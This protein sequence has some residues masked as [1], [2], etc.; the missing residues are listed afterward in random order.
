MIWK[1]FALSL[2]KAQQI[3]TKVGQLDL[4]ETSGPSSHCKL[5]ILGGIRKYFWPWPNS[6]R[7]AAAFALG[8]ASLIAVNQWNSINQSIN[9]S[10]NQLLDLSRRIV[11]PSC[12]KT[13]PWWIN[14]RKGDVAG[15]KLC[16]IVKRGISCSEKGI[17][18]A[19]ASLSSSLG[20]YLKDL[21]VCFSPC[22]TC[23]SL[24]WCVLQCM[25]P[26]QWNFWNRN[27]LRCLWV[28]GHRKEELWKQRMKL[29][30]QIARGSAC[31]CSV[32][33]NIS[34]FVYPL[35]WCYKIKG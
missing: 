30:F 25:I 20:H 10:I 29:K 27:V 22:W 32:F 35:G 18:K 12:C 3:S 7:A 17:L 6:G 5:G 33:N 13:R 24:T 2:I 16:F 9:L 8:I 15:W 4:E 21:P 11:H 14:D 1:N 28:L 23:N 34:P 26:Q 31:L 19:D